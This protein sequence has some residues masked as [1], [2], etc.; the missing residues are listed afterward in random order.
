MIEALYIAAGVLLILIILYICF[1]KQVNVFIVAVTGKKRIQKKLCN[2]CKNNDLLIINDLWLPVG[3][4]KYKHLDTIIFGNKYIYVTRIVKQIGEIRFSLDDQKWRVIY[5]RQLTLID[6]PFIYNRRVISSLLNAVNGIEQKDLK[7]LV[8][9]TKTCTFNPINKND[10]E[11]IVSEKEAI[12]LINQIEANSND[13]IFD[14]H[15]IERYCKAFYEYGLKA[16]KAIKEY[17]KK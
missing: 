15:E 16:E 13:D 17:K 5:N 3:E 1:Y 7:S 8:V 11:F 2:H 6:N 4:G 9:L 10:S 12:G 14:P